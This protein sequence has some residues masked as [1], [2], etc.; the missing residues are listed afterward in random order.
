MPTIKYW[1]WDDLAQAEVDLAMVDTALGYPS[2]VTVS[3]SLA[4]LMGTKYAA[5]CTSDLDAGILP[6]KDRLTQAE[7]EA[8]GVVFE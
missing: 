8:L 7:A 2:D 3:Y 5:P 4:S 1:I 6:G